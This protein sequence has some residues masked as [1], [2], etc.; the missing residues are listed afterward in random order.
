MKKIK[1][2]ILCKGDNKMKYIHT[3]QQEEY[4][5]GIAC[6]ASIFKY[7]H[8]HHGI[9]YL[10]DQVTYKNGYDLKD[11]IS[12]FSQVNHFSCKAV[13]IN[14]EDIGE[15]LKHIEGPCIA[16]IN[17][18]VNESYE[19][20]YIIVYKRNRNKLVISD[21]ANDKISK[22]TIDEF[23]QYTTGIFLL[24]ESKK[25]NSDKKI[26]Y[27]QN[28]FKELIKNNKLNISFV[29][30]LSILFVLF[31]ISNS[32]FFKLVIDEIIPHNYEYLLLEFALI[33]LGINF[34]SN[35][36]DYLRTYIIN[37]AAIKLD[38]SISKEFFRKILKLPINFFENRDDGDIISRFNDIYYIRNLVNVA[39]ISVILN[40]VIFLGIGFVLYNINVL[41]FF[42]VLI[43][44]LILI[45][46]TFI[47][48]DIIQKRNKDSMSKNADTQSFLIQFIK[49]MNNIYSLN[50][51]EYFFSA[52]NKIFNRELNA[53][54]KEAVTITN[55]NGLKKLIQTSFSI[56]LLYVGAKQIMADTM[57]LGDLLFINSLTM[58]MLSS[59]SGLIELQGEI[60]K[61]LVAKERLTDLMNYPVVQNKP[62]TDIT[63]V[64]DI[65]IQ[66][67]N[68]NINDHCIIK[69]VNMNISNNDKVILIGESGSGKTTFSKLLNK[70]YQTNPSQIY[71]NGVD[72]NE[73]NDNSLRKEIIYL[74][75]NPFLFKNTI[76]ENICMGEYFTE[77]EIIKACKIAHIYDV[78]TSLPKGF[79][80]VINNSHSNLSTGQKQRLCLARAI[81]HK[82]SVLI[83]DES[84]SNVDSDNF[85]KIYDALLDLNSIIIFITHNPE[86]ITK[87]D[88]KFIFREKSIFE[89]QKEFEK[90]LN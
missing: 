71:I 38:K 15:A 42:T 57:S 25:C 63:R 39:F 53:A 20:H 54:L 74:N 46:I 65:S 50:K 88:K 47:Y 2:L 49:N 85:M 24:I 66:N 16:L 48:Y 67:L 34:L 4:D 30:F 23:K 14:K 78:I 26:S 10:R 29:L 58:F 79:N 61:S 73:V 5:C 36:F 77:D 35:V 8:L 60:Q 82:P 75:E 40:T 31:S 22:I 1:N 87:Y 83:L 41:L 64:K 45:A 19:G 90:Q 52:F 43:L 72:I 68:F 44:T 21:P 51:K 7:Y 62:Q 33:F 89:M 84:L 56:I 69:N 9:N 6:V 70:L 59:L 80:F 13:E 18:G 3:K 28:F 81:L 76:K 11:L 12:L 55:N 17:K 27:H 86:Y 37:K 32:F